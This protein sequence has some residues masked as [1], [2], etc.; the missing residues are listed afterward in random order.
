MAISI[1]KKPVI[2]VDLDS[3]GDFVQR[4]RVAQQY[5]RNEAFA[6]A[7]FSYAFKDV[8]GGTDAESVEKVHQFLRQITL[9]I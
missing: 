4:L 6:V 5:L 1:P 8:W 7:L 3:S 9:K 2:A